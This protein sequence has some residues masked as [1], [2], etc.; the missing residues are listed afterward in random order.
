MSFQANRPAKATPHTL[1]QRGFA[2]AVIAASAAL[3]MPACADN[4]SS[5]FIR[6]CVPAEPQDAGCITP[7]PND[8]ELFLFDG[9]LDLAFQSA[10]SC[11]LRVGNQLVQRGTTEQV[12]TETSRVSLYAADVRLTDV[13]GNSIGYA[14]GSAVA[15]SVPLSGFVD[16][17]SGSE[18]GYG[19]ANVLMIDQAAGQAIGR[20]MATANLTTTDV[21]AGIIVYGRTLGGQ[22]LETPEWFFPIKVC[23]GCACVQTAEGCSSDDSSSDIS[24]P[25]STDS[26]IDCRL[27]IA[28][29]G[30]SEP[31]CGARRQSAIEYYADL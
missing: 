2:A 28:I 18:A 30:G 3:L 27:G 19:Y 20:A 26:G 29:P 21:L 7:E 23:I 31:E 13:A 25:C 11:A 5:L 12:R 17:G 14:D 16:P 8:A 9:R 15:F 1:I 24:V 4:E 22:E 10:Y 6:D